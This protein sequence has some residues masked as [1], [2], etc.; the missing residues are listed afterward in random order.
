MSEFLLEQRR[1]QLLDT[2]AVFQRT[3]SRDGVNYQNP[4]RE[5]CCWECWFRK[6]QELSIKPL[7]VVLDVLLIVIGCLIVA[8]LDNLK[9]T[10]LF[11]S[12]YDT[13]TIV[14]KITH[15]NYHNKTDENKN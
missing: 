1:V 4:V 2:S 14:V 8:I 11:H 10:F 15:L 12:E 13:I 7:I 3:S 5:H 9:Q 6:R